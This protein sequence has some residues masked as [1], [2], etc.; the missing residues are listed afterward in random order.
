MSKTPLEAVFYYR[1]AP[2]AHEEAL[3][4]V[5]AVQGVRFRPLSLADCGQTVGALVGLSG[6]ER[7][8]ETD[9]PAIEEEVLILHRF[10][11]RTIDRFLAALRKAGIPKIALKAVVTE[12]NAGWT[13]AALRTELCREHEEFE[14]QRKARENA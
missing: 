13:L 3:R 12:H 5:C 6:Y 1:P 14:A 7:T 10:D 11:G 9:A 2:T 4:R 8:D